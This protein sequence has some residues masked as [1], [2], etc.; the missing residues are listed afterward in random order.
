MKYTYT[1][2]LF[3]LFYSFS[4]S[5]MKITGIVVDE[6]NKPIEN[7]YVIIKN[8]DKVSIGGDL[9]NIEGIFTLYTTIKNVKL[10]IVQFN[11]IYYE[12]KLELN[13]NIDLGK[14][15]I[16]NSEVLQEIVI[17]AKKTNIKKEL[18]KFVVDNIS[19][20]QFSKG[21]N[22]YEV[23]NFIPILNSSE[24]GISILNKGEATIFINGKSVG[25]NDVALNMIKSIPASNIKKVEIIANPDS[26]YEASN[27][28]GIINIILKNNENE[29][30][31]GSISASSNQSYFN[32]QY[33]SGF[34]SYSKKKLNIT[35]GINIDN[36]K[37]FSRFNYLYNNIPSNQQTKI[38]SHT[39][40][41]N[42]NHSYFINSEY[43]LNEKNNIGLQLSYRI[44][45]KKSNTK[46][47]NIF[48]NIDS[49]ITN[50]TVLNNITIQSPNNKS[51]RVNLNYTHQLDSLGSTIYIDNTQI[52]RN[53][54]F[55]NNFDFINSNL[56]E[57]FRQ[58]QDEKFN[59]NASKI[60]VTKVINEDNKLFFGGNFIYSYIKN[61]FFH[62]NFDGVSFISDPLQTNNYAY[63]DK[64]LAGYVNYE[65]IFN[66]K[67][68]GK[69]GFRLEN[70]EGKGSTITNNN[71]T[72]IKNTYLFPS[73]SLLFM[74]NENNEISLDASSYILRPYYTQLNPFIRYNSSN[75]YTINNPNLLPT[76][77]YELAL[78]YSFK[79]RY[80]LNISYVYDKN[81]F[82]DFDLVLPNNFIQKT[83]ANYGNG[84]DLNLNFTYTNNFFNKNLNFTAI[85]NYKYQNS[86]GFYND[87]DMSF[88]NNSYSFRLKNQINLSKEKDF[89]MSL[90]YGYNSS[91]NTVFGS[92]NNLHSLVLDFTKTY[93][94]FNFSLSAY[95]LL[96]PNLNIVENKTLYN[97]F[98]NIEYFRN[99]KFS[100]RYNFGNKKIKK[101]E[102]KSSEINNRLL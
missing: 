22:S 21:K 7:I 3:I 32:S 57:K 61:N 4:Y 36:T 34:L 37:N 89:N 20:S 23:L 58:I 97:F 16:N 39:I 27:K 65:K 53:N 80:F 92:L 60:D 17:T 75:S 62:G 90:I 10:Q 82:N 64:T 24:K 52:I 74:P 8:S 11:E 76:L 91:I 48:K 73:L 6:N 85:F 102:D 5:Q 84:N 9:T 38:Q 25:E 96:R 72:R 40:D 15:K 46:T 88:Q 13:A 54:N 31:K 79:N 56:N 26:K 77:S 86:Y 87:F 71:I 68:E 14:I 63:T 78:G 47:D 50:S 93:K 94:N 33:G 29:G 69:I 66:E 44:N 19:T 1:L 70:F 81:L 101:I 67:W 18:G 99:I 28:N 98:K 95:D 35:S 83:T 2:L 30:I 59:I 43:K 42:K 100:L 12:K 55:N 41:K 49:D 51:F 45:E